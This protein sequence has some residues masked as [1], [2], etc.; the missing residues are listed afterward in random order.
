MK[1]NKI[2]IVTGCSG[3][4]GSLI[5]DLFKKKK[6]KV[7]GID[8]KKNFNCEF[9]KCDL[10]KPR[11]LEKVY[12][13]IKKKYDNIE[14]LV[15]CAGFIH[16]ELMIKFKNGIQTHS[17]SNWKNVIENN[18]NVTFYNTKFY[19]DFFKDSRKGNKLII[20]FSSVNSIGQIGQSAY[21]SAKAAIE[22][23]TKVWAKELSPLKI[24]VAC[25][26]PGY[27]NLDSTN[28]NLNQNEK[29]KIMNEIPLKRFGKSKEILNGINFI[30]SNQ[31]FNGKILR[32]DGG[33]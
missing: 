14:I 33:K 12:K 3:S 20:N 2:A 8:K 32:L 31:Y 6:I 24:R 10:N 13:K 7:I 23:A 9:Y 4:I 1:N 21:S 22:V 11:S 16:N 5:T 19:V 26:S 27:F 15:N 29:N 18:L 25:I 28:K 17:L 30:I